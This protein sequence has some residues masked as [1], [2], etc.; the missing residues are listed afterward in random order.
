[1]DLEYPSASDGAAK[2][3]KQSAEFFRKG[4]VRMSDKRHVPTY[5]EHKQ[6]GQAIVTLPDGCSSRR[7]IL[8]GKY[9]TEASRV[10]YARV[11]SEW[12]TAGRRLAKNQGDSDLTVS[13][14]MVAFWKHAEQH[15]R[16]RDGT[17]TSELAEYRYSLRI[18]K[19]L[20]GNAAA[21]SFGPLA[22]KAVRQ[23]MIDSGWCRGVVNQRVGRIRRMFRWA[24]ES[25]LVGPTVL[26]GLQAVRGLQ[27][28]RSK[29]RETE[30]IRPVSE[31]LV[32]ATLTYLQAP[33][34]A[35]VRLQLVT[36]MRPGE[37]VIMRAM[38][39]DMTGKVWL[40]RPGS[41]QGPHGQ[42][43]TA[44]RGHQRVIAIG[45]Q[46]QEI[47]RPFLKTNLNAYLFSPKEAIAMFRADQ[48]AK[49]KS[50]VQP[51][52]LSRRKLRA[53][54]TPGERYTVSSYGKAIVAAC[55]RAFPP[56]GVLARRKGETAKQWRARLTSQQKADLLNWCREHRWHPNQL[57]H[58]KATEI[59]R[60]FGLDAARVVLGHR[61]PQVTETYAEIDVNKA[62]EV[63]ARLG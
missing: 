43:K 51:S 42:H 60:E 5:R 32:N 39:L 33:V 63:M 57:R 19:E 16:H 23:K 7:D 47:I 18:L 17:P 62:T 25:E 20:Y 6:S 11:I 12:E 56:S 61:S 10:E 55:I 3:P 53:T 58:T 9:G 41:D 15:Y 29:A 1:L 2:K 49:R 30:P 45:P 24:V 52:Q 13:E 27:R 40:Y 21:G 36:G 26:H 50:R 54:K 48:R 8:L 14:L 44:W 46:G 34:V 31:A 38:D 35:M 59:R 28:G 4:V 22:L 37:V